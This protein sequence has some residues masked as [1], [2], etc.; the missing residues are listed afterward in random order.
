MF[1]SKTLFSGKLGVALYRFH[2]ARVF[3]NNDYEEQAL[4][5]M[6]ELQEEMYQGTLFEYANGLAGIGS[7]ISYLYRER[8]IEPSGDNYFSEIDAYFF[9]RVCFEQHSDL[10]RD[11]GLIGIGCYLL[12]RIQNLPVSDNMA[13]AKLR[14]LL[15]LVQDVLFA[16]LDMNGYSYPFLKRET[17]PESVIADIK[18][19]LSRMH[20]T[21]LCPEL[22]RRAIA[23]IDKITT[24]R[25]DM[26]AQLEDAHNQ[27]NTKEFRNLMK[28]IAESPED[29]SAKKLAELQ[30]KD[31]SL[32]AWWELF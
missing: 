16:C 18:R 14:H 13:S 15:L 9:N 29:S 19:F 2:Y 30:M 20:K 28:I 27:N 5:L 4:V 32:P 11:T 24:S 7:A 6:E 26:F 31:M 22:T 12:N 25:Q 23:I 8:F 3:A 17:L 1:N 21:D 10:S